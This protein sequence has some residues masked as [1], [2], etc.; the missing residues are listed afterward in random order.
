MQAHLA[1]FWIPS[2]HHTPRR[3]P[4]PRGRA[5]ARPSRG[6]SSTTSSSARK[7][8]RGS[9]ASTTW[10]LATPTPPSLTIEQ[11]YPGHPVGPFLRALEP[12]W[13]IQV[14]PDDDSHDEAFFDAM[15]EVIERCDRRLRADKDD[16]DGM[17]FKAG[18]LAFRGRLNTDR[19]NW[20]RAARD[21]QKAHAP[22]GGGPQARSGE[23]RPAP[24]SG[25]VRLPG[26]RRAGQVPHPEALRPPV[27][28]GQPGEGAGGALRGRREREVRAH[29]GGVL[30]ASR[31]ITSSSGTTPRRSTTRAGCGSAIRTTPSS[32]STRGGP[33]PA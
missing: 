32:T 15:D 8:A 31:S 12:W 14:D 33:S 19:K 11:R 6:R 9:T 17:F 16:L 24:G 25:P 23:P 29:R 2:N 1:R 28:E 5:R 27:P 13:Q 10:T 3:P 20:L 30:P 7:P 4:L 21:G 26:G 22:A 18:A